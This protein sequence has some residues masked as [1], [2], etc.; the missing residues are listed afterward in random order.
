M[1]AIY[2]GYQ[3]WVSEQHSGSRLGVRNLTALI[4]V[5]DDQAILRTTSRS[6]LVALLQERRG[7]TLWP[8]YR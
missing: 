6:T 7:S 4:E 8:T 1:I 5:S 3:M 2:T